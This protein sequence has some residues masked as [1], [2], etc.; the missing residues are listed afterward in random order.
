[1]D[2]EFKFICGQKVLIVRGFWRGRTAT[3]T[4]F[5]FKYWFNKGL[6][7]EVTTDDGLKLVGGEE[8]LSPI[9]PDTQDGKE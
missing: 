6:R 5:F 8:N 9:T 3:I 2:E 1:M 7:Y 4:G